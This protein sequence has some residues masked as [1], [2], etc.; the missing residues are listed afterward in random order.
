M[1]T[2]PAEVAV[3]VAVYVVDGARPCNGE[4]VTE[5]D[6]V[7]LLPATTWLSLSRRL[8]V[9][10]DS[11][12]A[13]EKVAFTSVV[14]DMDAAAGSGDTLV[15]GIRPIG[16]P[17]PAVG[18]WSSEA[19]STV[20]ADASM[21]AAGVVEVVWVTSTSVTWQT[22]RHGVWGGRGGGDWAASSRARPESAEEAPCDAR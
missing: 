15:T 1:A 2:P 16:V 3:T 17:S 14:E 10:L 12:M 7:V 9:T 21:V 19:V 5:F 22:Y 18:A 20:V 13:R 4:R 8:M 11:S 6:V